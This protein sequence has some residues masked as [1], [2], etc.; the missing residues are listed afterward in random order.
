M[1]YDWRKLERKYVYNKKY[2]AS[3]LRNF[4][5]EEG[6]PYNAYFKERTKNWTEKK[7]LKQDQISTTIEAKLTEEIVLDSVE[8]NKRHIGIFN[9]LL[10]WSK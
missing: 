9:I 7:R 8:A 2:A 10:A 3:S 1:T 5:K 4:A 6:I